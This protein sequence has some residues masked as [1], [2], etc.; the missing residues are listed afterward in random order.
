MTH[1]LIS[2]IFDKNNFKQTIKKLLEK[3]NKKSRIVDYIRIKTHIHTPDT[4]QNFVGDLSIFLP[5][6]NVDHKTT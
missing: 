6:M 1:T 4:I 5:N 3:N 2:K